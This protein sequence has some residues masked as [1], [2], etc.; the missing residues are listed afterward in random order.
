MQTQKQIVSMNQNKVMMN[1]DVLSFNRLAYRVFEELGCGKT[2]VIDEIGKTFIVRKAA[3]Q[4]KDRLNIYGSGLGK[5][6][7]VNE[8]KSLISEMLQYDIDEEKLDE[9]IKNNES[10]KLLC[11]KL[12]DMKIIFN[13]FNEYRKEKYIT[14]EEILDVLYRNIE[15]SELLRGTTIVID[16]FTGLHQ[17]T[18]EGLR[19][20]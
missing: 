19:K 6:G 16:G 14:S 9:M 7:L 13:A 15:K 11:N 8:M 20:N 4:N 17:D 3:T 5:I 12:K 18:R 1:I 10:D 2:P